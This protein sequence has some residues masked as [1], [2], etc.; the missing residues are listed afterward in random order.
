LVNSAGVNNFLKDPLQA[1]LNFSN[2]GFAIDLG[3]TYQF[4][5]KWSM[6][7][8]IINMGFI[9]WKDDVTNYSSNGSFTFEGIELES[10]FEDETFSFDELLDTLEENLGLKESHNAYNS[11]LVPRIYLS[12]SFSPRASSQINVLFYGEV[13]DGF[14]PAMAVHYQESFNKYFSLGISYSIKNKTYANFGMSTVVSFW[15]MQAFFVSDNF[16][17]V[18][19]PKKSKSVNFRAGINFRL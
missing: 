16:V 2:S 6:A 9:R 12:G 3:G 18:F 14:Q 17:G 1:A 8:S 5:D 13:F 7:A 11:P 19:I 10:L 15:K 4:N